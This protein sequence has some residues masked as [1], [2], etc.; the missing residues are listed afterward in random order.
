MLLIDAKNKFQSNVLCVKKAQ[1]DRTL[2]R[3]K[4]ELLNFLI[5]QKNYLEYPVS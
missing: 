5:L 4:Q 3:Q 1:L 2:N